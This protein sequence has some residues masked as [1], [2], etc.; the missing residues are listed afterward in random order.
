MTATLAAVDQPTSPAAGRPPGSRRRTHLRLCKVGGV[1][2]SAE[3]RHERKLCEQAQQGNREALGELLRRHGP[4]LYRSVLLPRLGSPAQAEEAL[5]VTYLK[6]VERFEQFSWQ[7]VGVYPWLRVIALRVALD[8]LRSGKRERLFQ[9]QDLE[10]E[11]EATPSLSPDA[12]ADSDL[13][14]ARQHLT[15]LLRLIHPRYR[16]AIELRILQEKSREQ[17]AAALSVSVSTFDVVLHRALAAL[18]K[19]IR[20]RKSR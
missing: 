12:L 19:A 16:E 5:S 14:A 11:L 2:P 3:L 4:R 20:A 6:V 17:A 15:E 9:P 7:D 1:E 13:R 18:K 8:H 10:A